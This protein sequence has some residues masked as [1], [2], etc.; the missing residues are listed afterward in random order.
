MDEGDCLDFDFPKS[1]TFKRFVVAFLIAKND[2]VVN[3]VVGKTFKSMHCNREN[4]R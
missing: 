4:I 2:N 1:K 3:K